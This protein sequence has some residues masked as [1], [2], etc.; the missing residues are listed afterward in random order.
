MVM[1]NYEMILVKSIN[2]TPTVKH[3]EFLVKDK[4]DFK[5][6]QWISLEII[7]DGEKYKRAFSIANPQNNKKLI[8][9]CVKIVEKGIGSNYLNE[10]KKGEKINFTGP[11]GMFTLKYP[12]PNKIVLIATGAGIAP[13][14]AIL[15]D[16]FSKKTKNEIYLLFGNR[17]ENEIIYHKAFLEL[18]KKNKN[19]HYFN[20]L[21]KPNQKWK[22]ETGHVQDLVKKCFKD[23]SGSDFYIC[24]LKDMVLETK[25][26]LEKLKV[27]KNNINFERYN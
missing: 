9:L 21:S 27:N 19:F 11:F 8:E 24:G 13:M 1:K 20:I 4:L 14:R 22:G 2:E 5:T 15:I 25:E 7:K 12:T 18:A 17:S 16:L 10:M 6:G 3:L 26:L 23:I